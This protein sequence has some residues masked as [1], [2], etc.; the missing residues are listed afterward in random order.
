MKQA[1]LAVRPGGRVSIPGVY[2]GMTDK[3]PLGALMEKGLQVRSGQTHVQRYTKDLLEK[4]EDGTLD[5][6][7]LISH[8]LPLGDAAHGERE[9]SSS[10]NPIA[11]RE[12]LRVAR[13]SARA[14]DEG[15]ATP[16]H[17][18]AQVTQTTPASK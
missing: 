4:I 14:E 18:N 13:E 11:E 16:T 1:I 7:F 5:T 6:T 12:R 2:G 15:A 3:F 9:P 17:S 10:A 8:R